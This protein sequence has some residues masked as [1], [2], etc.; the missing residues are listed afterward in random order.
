MGEDN[1]KTNK[2]TV[3]VDGE[4]YDGCI[5][6]PVHEES[7]DVKVNVPKFKE[8][9]NI[10]MGNGFMIYKTRKFRKKQ[11]IKACKR[12]NYYR[13]HFMGMRIYFEWRNKPFLIEKALYW[14]I[15]SSCLIKRFKRV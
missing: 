14:Y 13:L 5:T 7:I 6:T 9:F 15:V 8:A 11:V 1:L 3:Y 2:F 4:E 10:F 12:L